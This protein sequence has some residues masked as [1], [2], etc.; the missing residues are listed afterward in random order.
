M[1]ILIV[2]DHQ[3]FID[4]IRHVLEKI[5]ENTDISAANSAEDA[6]ALL[7]A[8]SS[9]ELILVDLVM[10]GMNGISIIQRMREQ[11]IWTP[12]V[13][14]SGEENPRAIKAAL[15]AGALGFIPKSAGS[16][17]MLAGLQQVLKG[18]FFVPDS[19]LS[20]I[21]AIPPRRQT[22]SQ[23][24]KRQLQV[25]KFLALGYSNRQIAQ[26]LFL[27]EHTI[28]AHVSSLFIELNA[29]NRTDCVHIA[30]Q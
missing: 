5:T 12:L 26:T 22:S 25:L 17:D 6:I 1:K 29:A 27:T 10:P 30:Q 9:Y 11:G 2:D 21:E 28:K 20:R 18:G 3:L 13:I 24:T 8:D 16:A 14:M 7:E 23:L 15:E 19:I 4:G